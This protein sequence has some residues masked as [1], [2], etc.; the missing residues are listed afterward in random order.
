MRST[1]G[2][3]LIEVMVVVAIIGILSAISYP[4]YQRYVM[5]SHR[6][7]AQQFMMKMDSRQ[8]QIL[9]EQRGFA[10]AP[11]ALN[12]SA[13][14][15][16]CTAVNCTNGRYTIA[17]NP[18]VDNTATPPSYTICAVP[19]AGQAPDGTLTLTSGGV[20]MRRTGTVCNAGA[21]QGW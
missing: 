17:F 6:S 18:A 3:T 11:N 12:V 20:K 9:I 2:F 4:S 7:D 5:R 14:G 10:T 8:K 13:Q 19:G 16:S 21:D 1:G 15:W